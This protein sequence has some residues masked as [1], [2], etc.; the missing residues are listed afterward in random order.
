MKQII[1]I[2]ALAFF[3]FSIPNN[4]NA[5]NSD[6]EYV[7]VEYMKVKP[8]MEDQYIECEKVWK[9]VHQAR[10]KAGTI[11]GWELERVMY[12]SGTDTEYDYLVVTHFKNWKAIEAATW[13][14]L[15]AHIDALPA[16]KKAIA[17][18]AEEYRDLVK[19]EIWTALDMVFAPG[20]TRPKY[21]VENFM[22]IPIGG[23]TNWVEM[24]SRF[25]KPVHEKSIAMGFRSGWLMAPLVMP[26]GDGYPYQGST[27]DFYNSWEDMNK[28]DQA[29]WDAVYP[30]MSDSHSSGRI[31]G[32]RT[33]VLTEVRELVDFI[34]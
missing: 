2:L 27:V 33:L 7:I 10:K 31:V 18:K 20:T 21:A 17:N 25:V 23:W 12:P 1:S 8:G 24:E 5:Q 16:D 30:G 26:R 9:T 34:E 14:S 11:T 29:A 6:N 4:I 19:R 22:K 13:S 3:C 15:S 28:S 32:A